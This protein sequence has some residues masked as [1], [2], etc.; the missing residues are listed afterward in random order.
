MK[1]CIPTIEQKGMASLVSEHFGRA[2]FHIVVDLA[3]D[4][5]STLRKDNACGEESHGHC[6]PV[7]LL[8]HNRVTVVACKGIGRGAVERMRA[9]GIAVYATDA[10]T[11]REVVARF[12]TSGLTPVGAQHVCQGH[13]D[14]DH[15]HAHHH[16]H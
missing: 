12:K 11:V 8:L 9:N 5:C 1:L 6:L 10:A 14:H 7:D 15:D 16:H 2:P 3:S 4:A 13:H